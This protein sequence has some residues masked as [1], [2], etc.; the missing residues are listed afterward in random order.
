MA[1]I[2]FVW[3]GERPSIV[4]V[5]G[6]LLGLIGLALLVQAHAGTQI[7]WWPA[8]IAVFA[9]V[10]WAFGSIFTRRVGKPDDVVL[11]TALQMLAGGALLAIE[12][13]FTGEW[14]ALDVRAISASSWAG[15]AWLV[16]C[17]SLLGYSA[18]QYTMH[19]ATAALASTYAYVN[20][21]VS[22]ILGYFLFDERLTPVQ[23][24]AS[25]VIIAGVALMMWPRPARRSVARTSEA[26]G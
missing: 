8:V 4:S 23:G 11:A 13:G 25:A 15:F 26:L 21:I 20:P 16:V 10:S 6:M 7:P 17:G 19:A 3:G 12:A 9:S 2:G 5:A 1:V 18:Y 14:R 24:M 22:V